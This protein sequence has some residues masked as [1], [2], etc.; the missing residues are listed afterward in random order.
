MT[1]LFVSEELGDLFLGGLLAVARADG[2]VKPEEMEVLRSTAG[3]RGF[4]LPSDEDL[5][6]AEDVTPEAL[7]RAVRSSAGVYRAGASTPDEIALGF[8]EAA[9][10]LSLADHEL[11][12]EEAAALRE[13]AAAL[14]ASTRRI[15]GWHAVRAF[16]ES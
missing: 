11:V 6:F 8:L 4:R 1:H 12:M 10:R 7:A 9:L 13:F 2:I 3:D 14:G 15:A 16:E 5:L